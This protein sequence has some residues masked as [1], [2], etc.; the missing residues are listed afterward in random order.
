MNALFLD[1]LGWS[2]RAIPALDLTVKATLVLAVAGVAVLALHRASAAARHLAWCLGL[3]A[4]LALPVLSLVV[5]GW[6][7]RILPMAAERGH[8]ARISGADA[9]APRLGPPLAAPGPLDDLTLDGDELMGSARATG[10]LSRGMPASPIASSSLRW[11]FVPAPSWSWLWAVW[12]AG[13]LAVLSARLAGWIALGRLTRDAEPIDDAEW[14]TQARD[15]AAKLGLTRR[16]LLLRGAR[17]AMPM[18]WGWI[19]PVVLLPAEADSWGVDRRRGVLLHELAHVKRLD[20]LT[21]AIARVACAVYWFHPLAWIATRRMGVERERAC[22]DVVLLAG[23]RASEYAGHL[24]EV[25]RGLR[26]HQVAA[27]AVLAMARPSQLEGRLLAILDPDRRRRGPGR[28]LALIALMTAMLMLVPLGTLQF[29]SRASA[30]AVP[31]REPIVDDPRPAD[32]AARM[33]VTGRVLDPQGKPVP[34]AAVMV[35]V[36]SKYSKRPLLETSVGGAMTA[37]EGRCDDSGQ[38]RIELPRTTSARQYGLTVTA[39]APG[40]GVGWAELD[41]DADPPVADIALRPELIVWGRMF[42]VKGEP[43]AGVA[44]RIELINPVVG[45]TV[46]TAVGRPDFHELHRRDFPAWPGPAISDDQG[47]F[48]VRGLSRGLLCRLLIEDPRFAI[49]LSTLQTAEEVD[50]RLPIA[51]LGTIKVDPGPNPGPIAIALQPANAIVGRVTYGDT[52]G[53]VPHALIASGAS[54]SEADAE[55]RFRVHSAGPAA[56]GR[57][58]VRAQAPDGAPYLMTLKQGE[59][60]KGA[61]EQSVD[62][63]LPRGAVVR[64]RVTEEGTGRPVAG[65]VVRVTSP[66]SRGGPPLGFSVPGVTGPDGTYRVAAPAGPGYL[67]VQGPDDDYVLREFGGEGAM[68]AAVAGRRRL[69][70]HAYRA[71]ELKPG[72]PD[73]EVDLT[74]RRGV[75]LH[76][77]AVGPDG[78][79]ARDAWICSRLMLRTQP[80]GGWK[81]FILPQDHS[82]SPV[83]DGRF[84]LHGLDPDTAV[85][86]P[87]FFLDPVRKLGATARLSGRSEANGPVTV[88]LEP[89]GMARARLVTSDGKPLARYDA[90]ALASIVVTPGPLFGG[91]GAEDGPLFAEEASVVSLDP[92]NYGS[93]FQSDAQGQLTLPALIPGATYRIEDFTPAFGGGTPAIRKEFT[94]KPSETIDLGDILIARPRDRNSS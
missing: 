50:A 58:G 92:V 48:T 16:I 94:V 71:V 89:C 38:F 33:A 74:L 41:P 78:Q 62:I 31:T 90:R 67:V 39:M 28:G 36:P 68:Y 40:Y 85:E 15:L 59:W 26:A 23:A 34:H 66:P 61:I 37:H 54:Y 11:G 17:A 53:P 12:L 86:V 44:L 84:V 1:L 32:P 83:R 69:Y 56:A 57:F 10:S 79:P 20:C 46:S 60:P 73:H 6:S 9:A 81:L 45:G 4:A 82:R 93:D 3:G 76:G 30:N 55:G 77:R 27:L 21:Q 88:R 25:A 35:I 2:P 47:R 49:P 18:T 29:G 42:D 65:A 13:V 87:T 80:D 75:A 22:D 64:G 63:A 43:A 51:R 14:T 72:G 7:W 91:R 52:G 24:L 5:P 8:H 19:R 70:A